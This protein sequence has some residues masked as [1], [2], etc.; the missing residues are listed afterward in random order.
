[1]TVP[2][3]D[4]YRYL[5]N[6]PAIQVKQSASE[7]IDVLLTL[8]MLGVTNRDLKMTWT[9]LFRRQKLDEH[10]DQAV[11]LIENTRIGFS[12]IEV[13]QAELLC[14]VASISTLRS[15]VS[16]GLT[17]LEPKSEG[18]VVGQP[19]SYWLQTG[20]AAVN[21]QWKRTSPNKLHTTWMQ[22]LADAKEEGPLEKAARVI[23]GYQQD[24]ERLLASVTTSK[25]TPP[26]VKKKL[27]GAMDKLRGCRDSIRHDSK[28]L[29]LE[30]LNAFIKVEDHKQILVLRD[31]ICPLCDNTATHVHMGPRV[32]AMNTRLC[33]FKE[34]KFDRTIVNNTFNKNEEISREDQYMK[35]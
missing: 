13:V 27:K 26:A 33:K 34:V 15:D 28:E 19:C 25:K 17:E 1:V 35:N 12:P 20:L 16:T 18:N 10:L 21:R 23:G 11:S 5:K 14:N 24:L 4:G 7:Q 3:E 30:E 6:F 9:K 8:I 29:P 31:P 32:E 22:E 2:L